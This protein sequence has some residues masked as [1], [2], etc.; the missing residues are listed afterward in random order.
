MSTSKDSKPNNQTQP[1]RGHHALRAL[2]LVVGAPRLGTPRLACRPRQ[3]VCARC[4]QPLPWRNRGRPKAFCSTRCQKLAARERAYWGRLEG[5]DHGSGRLKGAAGRGIPD[6]AESRPKNPL[7]SM[8][9]KAANGHPYP[10]AQAPLTI[11]GHGH[12]WPGAARLDRKL[13]RRI[14]RMEV[15]L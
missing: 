3:K 13:R 6:A 7:V 4:W 8:R 15:G 11:F 10:F 5:L 1:T 14:I 12:H 9:C 2:G